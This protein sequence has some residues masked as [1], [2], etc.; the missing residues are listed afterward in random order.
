[1]GPIS[2]ICVSNVY[3]MILNCG[4]NKTQFQ[5]QY[6]MASKYYALKCINK[7]NWRKYYNRVLY[8]LKDLT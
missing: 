4:W 8:K 2:K 7:N 1:M 5:P 6:Q 3:Q